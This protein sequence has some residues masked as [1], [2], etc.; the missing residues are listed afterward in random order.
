MESQRPFPVTR[1]EVSAARGKA[2][3]NHRLGRGTPEW[4]LRVATAEGSSPWTPPGERVA[5]IP[6]RRRLPWWGRGR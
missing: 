2:I 3:I 4:I 5:P 6:R 1:R